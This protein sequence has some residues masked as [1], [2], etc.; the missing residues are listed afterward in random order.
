[1]EGQIG[2]FKLGKA[3]R[4]KR[5][6]TLNST[7]LLV[8]RVILYRILHVMEGLGKYIYFS[9]LFW[10]SALENITQDTADSK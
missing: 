10:G 8:F 4:S 2:F 7:Q 5:R 1:M 9:L 6:N 3:N